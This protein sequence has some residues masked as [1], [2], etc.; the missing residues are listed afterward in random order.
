MC[1]WGGGGGGGV[2]EG[3]GGVKSVVTRLHI[4]FFYFFNGQHVTCE[5]WSLVSWPI[6]SNRLQLYCYVTDCDGDD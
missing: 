2:G 4:Q 5:S 3:G 1:V 6:S